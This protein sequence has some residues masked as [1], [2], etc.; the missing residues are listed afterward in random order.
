MRKILCLL[1]LLLFPA[2]V[3]AF[4]ATFPTEILQG[5]TME[6]EVPK[7]T[8]TSLEGALAGKPFTFYETSR[9]PKD[10]DRISR[11]EF[12]DLLFKNSSFEMPTKE[13][14]LFSDVPSSSPYAESIY[15]ARSLGI[16]QG[17]EDGK[18][19]PYDYLTRAQAAKILILAFHPGATTKQTKIFNDLPR[20]HSLAGFMH[21]AIQTGLFQGYGDGTIKPDRHLNYSEAE[22]LIIRAVDKELQTTRV[23]KQFYR[24]FVGLHRINDIGKKTLT[25][26]ASTPYG[27]EER[28]AT[29]NVRGA[30]YPTNSFR[31][32]PSK[33]ALFGDTAYNKTWEMIDGSKKTTNPT[34]LWEGAFIVPTEGE[35]SMGFGDKVYING[36]FSGSHFGI[37]YANKTGTPV[38]ASNDG[39]VTLSDYTP[40]YGNTVIIDH[41][42]NVFTMYMHMSELKAIK[43]QSATKG[44]LIG[45]IGATG[46]ATGPH[47]H[48]THFIGD[49]IVNS[50]EWFEGK[51]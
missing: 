20:T 10:S 1:F 28:E 51:F 18:F 34:Q 5:S 41:G 24:G 46:I 29:I 35:V 23:M 50:E 22:I 32:A 21:Q 9:I 15:A 36:A 12:I 37:D 48:F 39:I 30:S 49:V 27:R 25:L 47:L 4:E 43:G 7:D 11:G 17:Y 45:T 13:I 38:Y 16:V 26:A 33:T 42:Q 14:P 3:F 2:Q 19:H 6:I 44:E 31:L 8:I 40:S